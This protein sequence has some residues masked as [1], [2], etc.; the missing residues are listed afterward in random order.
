MPTAYD[1]GKD[2]PPDP[3][4]LREKIQVNLLPPLGRLRRRERERKGWIGC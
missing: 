2:F 3:F 4:G 1:K